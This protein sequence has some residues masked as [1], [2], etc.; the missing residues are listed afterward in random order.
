MKHLI[1]LHGFL[2]S[3]ASVKAQQ[4]QAYF[5]EHMPQLE[6]HFPTLPGYPDKAVSTVELIIK[7]IGHQDLRFI[8]SSMGGFLSSYFVEKYG[9]KAVIVNPAVRPFELLD[10]YQGEH[11]NPNTGETFEVN[12]TTIEYLRS[13]D[14]PV[15]KT[16]E[17]Y[18]VLLQTED[19]TLDYKQAEEKYQGAQLVIEQ[20]GDHSFVD[21]DKHLATIK[22]FLSKD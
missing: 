4:T 14:T 17:S 21:Y 13:L 2:S 3:P 7:N 1:Y 22:D 11:V 10:D 8:G 16:P 6:M 18:M 5:K 19:E 15:I 9:G 12:Q 20:G